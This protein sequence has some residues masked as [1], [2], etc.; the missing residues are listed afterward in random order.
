MTLPE[1]LSLLERTARSQ[2]SLLE[3]KDCAE[4]AAAIKANTLPQCPHRWWEDAG[5]QWCG[6]C[7]ESRLGE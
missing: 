5:V 4:I 1:A 7:G 2:V 6:L 3:P